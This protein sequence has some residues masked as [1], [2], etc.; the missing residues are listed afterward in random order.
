[1]LE[2]LKLRGTG[3]APEL[4]MS[5]AP[6]LNLIA[7]NNGL[8]KSFLLDV[9]WWALSG[10]WLSELNGGLNRGYPPHP[11]GWRRTALIE[12]GYQVGGFLKRAEVAFADGEW[13]RKPPDMPN[14]GLDLVV[15][16]QADGSFAV[17]DALRH[18][19]VDAARPLAFTEHE[20]WN[21]L[22]IQRRTG[23]QVTVCN[24]LLNDWSRWI[25]DGGQNAGRME[26]L[27]C[28]LSP[29]GQSA[30]IRVGKPQRFSAEDARYVPTIGTA[31]GEF[32]PVLLASAAVRRVCTLAYML[33]W[34]WSEHSLGAWEPVEHGETFRVVLLFDEVESHLHPHWQRTMLPGLLH[35]VGSFPVSGQLIATTHSPLV[36]ASVEPH[37]G[38][39]DRLFH[40]DFVAGQ[41]RSTRCHGSSKGMR[42]TGWCRTCSASRKRGR[43]RQRRPLAQLKL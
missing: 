1:M 34:A 17:W 36:L 15:Y 26:D 39:E 2:Y 35:A 22:R 7:G 10:H 33:T 11:N 31:S 43:S 13:V 23:E 8:G 12:F 5:L 3:P 41:V 16:A 21:G 19:S 37:F 27:L 14:Y 9:A 28:R 24:G 42:S 38:D 6:R 4:E 29:P 18:S 32:E 20:V 40:L 25:A 30:D